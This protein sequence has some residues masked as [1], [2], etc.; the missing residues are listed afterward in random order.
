MA[1]GRE[2]EIAEGFL[3]KCYL[4]VSSLSLKAMTTFSLDVI[5]KVRRGFGVSIIANR[6]GERRCGI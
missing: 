4:S 2:V 3:T 1:M 5:R 6:H